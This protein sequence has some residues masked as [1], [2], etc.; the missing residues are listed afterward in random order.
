MALY[1]KMIASVACFGVLK[2]LFI[3]LNCDVEGSILGALE[4]QVALYKFFGKLDYFFVNSLFYD[5]INV[6]S[7]CSI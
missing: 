2:I 1:C 3:A 4:Q 6:V 5:L 7:V